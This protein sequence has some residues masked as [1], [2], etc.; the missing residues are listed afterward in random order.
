M[1]LEVAD[2]A[3]AYQ[4][5]NDLAVVMTLDFFTPIVDDPYDYGAIAAANSLSDIYAMG[6]QPV[7]ALNVAAMPEDL[8]LDIVGE[9]FRGG[10][11]KAHEAGIVV[12]G[13]HTVRD[14]EPK[15]GLVALGTIH[16]SRLKTKGGARAGD[17]LFLSKP[18]GTGVVT[19]ALM[20]DRAGAE[21]IEAA[22]R[23]MLELNRGA[24]QLAQDLDATALTDVTGFGLLGHLS[25][26]AK[27]GGVGFEVAF[28]KLPWLLGA[29]NLA[30]AGLFPGGAHD[31]RGHFEKAVRF[32]EALSNWHRALCFSPETSGGLLL[33]L[34][35]ESARE[36]L[37]ASAKLGISMFE[38]GQAIEQPGI[39]VLE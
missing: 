26:M 6:A 15:Y 22:T 36:V 32:D 2:D 18:L 38:V 1:G 30:R 16:P 12:A 7:L 17:R 33:T 31:N 23:S 11:D 5:S 39:T 27:T 35:A 8:S 19:T 21:E 37:E 4:V 10:A 28:S 14:E 9:I 34:S 24:A 13:G 3:A 20:Q 25:E 29:E